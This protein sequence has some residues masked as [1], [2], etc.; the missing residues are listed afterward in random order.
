MNSELLENVFFGKTVSNHCRRDPYFSVIVYN[1]LK[2]NFARGKSLL[3]RE[4][5]FVNPSKNKW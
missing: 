2:F 5:F 4:Y 3:F 1:A